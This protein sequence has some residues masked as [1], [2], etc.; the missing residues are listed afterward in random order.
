MGSSAMGSVAVAP[1]EWVRYSAQRQVLLGKP[2]NLWSSSEKGGQSHMTTS[3]ALIP[4]PVWGGWTFS[5]QHGM[6]YGVTTKETFPMSIPDTIAIDFIS[7][8]DPVNVDRVAQINRL[9]RQIVYSG[10]PADIKE[11]GEEARHYV[12]ELAPG[13]PVVMRGRT[14][15]DRG[16]RPDGSVSVEQ[17]PSDAA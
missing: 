4:H 7:L 14:G 11:F 6:Y 3:R 1:A 12:W 16:R 13:N 15:F 10:E 5:D 9:L 17:E 8:K 2:G